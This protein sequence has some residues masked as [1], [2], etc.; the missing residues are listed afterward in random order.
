MRHGLML[1]SDCSVVLVGG[2]RFLP[3]DTLNGVD[4]RRISLNLTDRVLPSL[5]L[6]FE[7]RLGVWGFAGEEPLCHR[8]SGFVAD[9]RRYSGSPGYPR[10]SGEELAL[11]MSIGR[12]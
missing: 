1:F 11:R 2:D 9:E 3:L 5:V 10:G 4:G 7:C 8:E 6:M 12:R